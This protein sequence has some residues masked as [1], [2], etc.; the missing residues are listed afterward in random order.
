VVRCRRIESLRGNVR[1]SPVLTIALVALAGACGCELVAGL[2]DKRVV[3][4]TG[5]TSTGSGGDSGGSTGGTGGATGGGGSGGM[6]CGTVEPD[7]CD[8][9]TGG[10]ACNCG[11]MGHSCRGGDCVADKCRPVT[12]DECANAHGIAVN[13]TGVYW[14]AVEGNGIHRAPLLGKA[15]T[16]A[17]AV[18]QPY[19]M[20][21]E[22]D[23]LFYTA[24]G[25]PMGKA[26]LPLESGQ[27]TS[28]DDTTQ[29]PGRGIAQTSD[30]VFWSVGGIS[31][32]TRLRKV[33]KAG[34][35]P[36]DVD[37]NIQNMV[38]VATD[39]VHVYYGGAKTL[40]DYQ[41][42]RIAV[43]RSSGAEVFHDGPA[44]FI[45]LDDQTVYW[46]VENDQVWARPKDMSADAKPVSPPGKTGLV[47][48]A[49]DDKYVYY[50]SF[51]GIF[52]N[53]KTGAGM[54]EVIVSGLDEP[55]LSPWGI[56][57]DATS[58]YW[59]NFSSSP[60]CGGRRVMRVAK[61]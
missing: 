9:G 40:D 29:V 60:E 41:L 13:D 2:D 56:A 4:G 44:L 35:E 59:T 27:A 43:D 51:G 42:F 23:R 34:G 49:V 21:L 30:T 28:I 52:R 26:P 12:I 45:A 57:V 50:G 10:L 7:P 48:V 14:A 24:D 11:R 58:V 6:S 47:G 20:V 61:P 22:C 33:P 46:T 53:D 36:K 18:Q 15:G 32:M 38:G 31:D 19:Q 55:M 8:E 25:A 1:R 17:V 39:G 54:E 37:T 3:G 16:E 5:S